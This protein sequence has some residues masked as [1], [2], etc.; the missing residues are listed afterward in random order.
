MRLEVFCGTKSVSLALPVDWEVV[1]VDILSSRCTKASCA[2]K[3]GN[4]HPHN[5]RSH[6]H[7]Q[8]SGRTRLTAI[9]LVARVLLLRSGM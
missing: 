2:D 9:N 3:G 4:T 6:R 5:C 7:L 8:G 1:S